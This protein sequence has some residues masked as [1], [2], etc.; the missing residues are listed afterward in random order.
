MDFRTH[1][2]VRLECWARGSLGEAALVWRHGIQEA[3]NSQGLQGQLLA[4]RD[5][6]LQHSSA[7]VTVI[8]T[9]TT[10]DDISQELPYIKYLLLPRSMLALGQPFIYLFISFNLVITCQSLYYY[11]YLTAVES[12]VRVG[13][14]LFSWLPLSVYD[15]TGAV[16]ISMIS[17]HHHTHAL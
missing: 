17:Q 7:C 4:I 2:Q 13:K 3:S 5:R 11:F 16:Y 15:M 14:R 1:R 10:S 12:E 6:W 9:G 8:S